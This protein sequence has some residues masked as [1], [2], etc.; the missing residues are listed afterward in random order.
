VSP[1]WG[2]ASVSRVPTLETAVGLPVQEAA[3]LSPVQ[4]LATLANSTE[5]LSA[6]E[7]VTRRAAVGSNA[8]RSH[9]ARALAVLGRQLRNALLG[10]L[11]VTAVARSFSASAPTR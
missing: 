8:M 5:G 4:V 1:R 6:D 9:H 3:T 10:L 11:L 2:S 7:V